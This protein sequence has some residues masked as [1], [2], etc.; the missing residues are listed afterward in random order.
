MDHVNIVVLDVLPIFA[1]FY[2]KNVLPCFIIE[3]NESRK[4]HLIVIILTTEEELHARQDEG[5]NIRG[6]VN[7]L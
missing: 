7:G 5:Q 1:Q 2:Q 3:E 6:W 4:L